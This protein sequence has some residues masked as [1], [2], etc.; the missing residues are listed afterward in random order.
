MPAYSLPGV[1][2]TSCNF[3]RALQ[4]NPI[5]RKN[6]NR[7]IARTPNLIRPDLQAVRPGVEPE[8][9]ILRLGT[10]PG[11]DLRTDREEVHAVPLAGHVHVAWNLSCSDHPVAMSGDYVA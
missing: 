7:I 10:D 11:V 3:E 5:Q 8:S 9:S 2:Y 1:T 4:L 6:S